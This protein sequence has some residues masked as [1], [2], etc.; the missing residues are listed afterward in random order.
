M[1]KSQSKK[2]EIGKPP[3][4]KTVAA[5]VVVVAETE[6]VSRVAPS[7]IAAA[8]FWVGQ[9]AYNPRAQH[10]VDSWERMT[11]HLVK[12]GDKGASGELLAGELTINGKHPDRT[13]YD[14]IGYLERRGAIS[15]KAPSK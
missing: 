10:N 8:T 14:F 9:A 15:R 5:P 2:K 1:A 7:S 3:V 11:K 12:G 13:H 4:V 6:E